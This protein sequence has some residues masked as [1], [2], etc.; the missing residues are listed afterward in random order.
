MLP[1]EGCPNLNFDRTT[2]GNPKPWGAG[3]IV[4]NEI[5]RLIWAG[6]VKLPNGTNHDAKFAASMKG[7]EDAFDRKNNK[8]KAARLR[9]PVKWRTVEVDWDEFG[10]KR[11]WSEGSDGSID[12]ETNR[13]TKVGRGSV[14]DIQEIDLSDCIEDEKEIFD[15]HAIIAK[16]LGPK[17]PRKDIQTWVLEN[18][19]SHVRVKF[20]PKGFF[21]AVFSCEEDRNHTITL[22]NWFRKEHPL[23]IQPWV[24]NFDPTEMA[25]YDKPMW[26]R[27][28]NLPIEYWSE[29][30]LEMIARSLG[31]L[32][33]IDEEIVEG[34]LYTY[35]RLKVAAIRT[36]PSEIMLHTADG[37]WKQQI[38]IEKEIEVC[39][40]CGSKLHNIVNCRMFVRFVRKAFKRSGKKI[41]Q[42][43]RA[44]EKTQGLEILL[45]EGP[46]RS[47]GKEEQND[48]SNT[49]TKNTPFGD[50]QILGNVSMVCPN[51]VPT[52]EEE[53]QFS[54]SDTAEQ[55]SDDD[56]LN[57]IEPRHISQSANIILGREKA[58]R[59]RKS[60]KTVREQRSKEKGIV[61]MM[62]FLN[63]NKGGK[64]SFGGR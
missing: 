31:T 52:V 15:R 7:L 29:G 13:H 38:E 1:P 27:L 14:D 60:H 44:K 22:K 37:N 9:R 12:R 6:S 53:L 25:T 55:G 51:E 42:V 26:I 33:E 41:E 17:L 2:Q 56:D 47:N 48:C 63:S 24:P 58:T 35:A 20:L 21:V 50:E 18:W 23:Y 64:A 62:K 54:E 46:R 28:Y 57:I 4:K 30:C 19:G 3:F 16:F 49:P 43:W 8:A 5:G 61:S 36:I 40:R 32:L 10:I 39:S 45:L 59:G 11:T 34:D